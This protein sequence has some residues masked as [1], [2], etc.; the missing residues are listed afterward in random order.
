MYDIRI[1]YRMFFLGSLVIYGRVAPISWSVLLDQ[2][3]EVMGAHVYMRL[4][5]YQQS[6]ARGLAPK[7]AADF[8]KQISI[9]ECAETCI[10]VSEQSHPRITV[11]D[12]QE[13][14]KAHYCPEDVDPRSEKHG[15]MRQSVFEKLKAMLAVLD[16][17]SPYFGYESGE[18]EI[19]LFEGLRD[20]GT[21]KKIFDA[22]MAEIMRKNHALTEE[23]AYKET[24]TWVSPYKNNVP[25]HSTG[26]A[27]DIHI[28]SNKKKSFCDMGRYNHDGMQA[29]TFS[30]D[31][32][33]TDAQKRNRLLLLIAAIEAGLTNYLYEFWHFSYG[34]KYAAYWLH[35]PYALYG[36]V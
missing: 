5:E 10:N 26:A 15:Y 19:K 7:I 36:T 33:V 25:V 18:L 16:R 30:D 4:A 3:K 20:I 13:A 24:C 8:I 28:W 6:Y 29:P 9:D 35:E 17:L 22:K 34:D 1:L 31:A 2:Y 14:L 23:E 11:M 12:E 27:I 32:S 21:Q